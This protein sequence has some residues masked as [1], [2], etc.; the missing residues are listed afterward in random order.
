VPIALAI[1]VVLAAGLGG[2]W[3]YLRPDRG[4]RRPGT[5]AEVSVSSL[6]DRDRP[7]PPVAGHVRIYFR[8]E[9]P[10]SVLTF[11]GRTTREKVLTLP[12]SSQPV[13]VKLH[14][15][16]YQPQELTV[17]PDRDRTVLVNLSRR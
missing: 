17:V 6:A 10:D 7:A 2:A 15:R 3:W 14:A 4:A 13:Q 5:H 1:V 16:L 11:R 9:P 12:R 8:V